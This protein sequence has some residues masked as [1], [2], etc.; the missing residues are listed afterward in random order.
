M[1]RLVGIAA[2]RER[3]RSAAERAQPGFANTIFPPHTIELVRGVFLVDERP[4]AIWATGSGRS[5]V[6]VTPRWCVSGPPRIFRCLGLRF[7]G[8]RLGDAATGSQKLW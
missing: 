8:D 1:D 7:E 6:P 2:E 4:S 5:R 3:E